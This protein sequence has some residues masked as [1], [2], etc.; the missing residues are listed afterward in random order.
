MPSFVHIHG[1]SFTSFVH[2][3]GSSFACIPA[4]AYQVVAMRG[5]SSAEENIF[6][7]LF[8]YIYI[9]LRITLIGNSN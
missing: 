7:V 8:V 3:H 4:V 5:S 9:L 1:S 2:I 6:F